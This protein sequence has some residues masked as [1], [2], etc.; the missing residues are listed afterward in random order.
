MLYQISAQPLVSSSSVG[1]IV[2]CGFLFQLKASIKILS[3]SS[4][5]TRTGGWGIFSKWT[6]EFQMYEM[7]ASSTSSKS[8]TQMAKLNTSFPLKSAKD[9]AHV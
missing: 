5:Y 1:D 2:V 3:L 6:R 9:M 4:F 8:T 7:L